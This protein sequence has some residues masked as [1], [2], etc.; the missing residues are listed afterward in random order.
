MAIGTPPPVIDHASAPTGCYS[1]NVSWYAS[2]P[3][4]EGIQKGFGLLNSLFSHGVTLVRSS[5]FV[6]EQLKAG[7]R[8]AHRTS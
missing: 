5:L 2:K 4:M 8:E 3:I 7:A 6:E 1:M